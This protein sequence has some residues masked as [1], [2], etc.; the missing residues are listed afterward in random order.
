M[1][2]AWKHQA[3]GTAQTSR[4]A[5][6]HHRGVRERCRK[7]GAHTC[8]SKHCA[9][10]TLLVACAPRPNR[11]AAVIQVTPVIASLEGGFTLAALV[12]VRAM[13]SLAITRGLSWALCAGAVIGSVT[14]PAPCGS[15]R[16]CTTF[17]GI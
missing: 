15:S 2:T 9:P 6:R 16:G 1:K 5:T 10:I 11:V 4:A 12:L 14:T 8:L 3:A 7:I 13:G 17:W